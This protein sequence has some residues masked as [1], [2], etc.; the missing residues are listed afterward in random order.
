VKQE[1][2]KE[3][4]E[5]EVSEEDKKVMEEN[6]K[7]VMVAENCQEV[8]PNEYKNH[9]DN[10]VGDLR[11]VWYMKV[12]RDESI[13]ATLRNH[14]GAFMEH[15]KHGI[16]N[17]LALIPMKVAIKVDEILANEMDKG[18]R[19]RKRESRDMLSELEKV[20]GD[21]SGVIVAIKAQM[22][23]G[24][25]VFKN[26]Q[27]C[28]N[29]GVR[30]ESGGCEC[31]GIYVGIH[32]EKELNVGESVVDEKVGK[33]TEKKVDNVDE[34]VSKKTEKKVDNVDEKVEEREVDNVDKNVE[35]NVDNVDEKV[36]DNV[37]N[38][39]KNVGDDVVDNVDNYVDTNSVKDVVSNG[40][41]F[42]NSLFWLLFIINY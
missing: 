2:N 26:K 12:D 1:E 27:E 30:V 19:L 13:K 9:I 29:G 22:N 5:Q 6:C 23:N 15:C 36:E 21:K 25:G 14:K 8:V 34:K 7:G 31:K 20:V 17:F 40:N 10:C 32:C 35:D 37:D 33:K 39:D 42:G 24:F 41:K 38:V 28:L 4:K 18:V 3:V 16:D 11:H